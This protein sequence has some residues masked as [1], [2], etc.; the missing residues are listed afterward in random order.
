MK[1]LQGHKFSKTVLLFF[2][3]FIS[4]RANAQLS[5]GGG[6]NSVVAFGIKK[7]YL[8]IHLFGEYRED[9]QSYYAKLSSTLSQ[10]ELS[11]T[12]DL[13]SNIP[14]DTS[15][16]AAVVDASQTFKYTNIE[17]G[18]RYYFG[19]DLDFGLSGYGGSHFNL[20]INSVNL[21][22]GSFDNTHYSLP[23]DTPYTGHILG[24]G[25]GLNGGV[26]YGFYFGHLYFDA[27]FNYLL[28][29]MPSN[30]LASSSTSIKQVV[31]VFNLGFKRTLI[32]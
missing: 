13:Q 9:E 12:L 32:W 5:L 1:Y 11:G 31:F 23:S 25:V 19:R 6:L 30:A 24:V 28:T 3:F 15:S 18:K 29:A 10:T 17:V 21:K 4:Y 16:F 22:T 2:L 14:N 26:Q 27:G 8:G 20:A 7:P